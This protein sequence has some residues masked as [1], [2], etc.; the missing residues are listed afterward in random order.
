MDPLD[1]AN[2]TQPPVRCKLF[3]CLYLPSI[4]FLGS[5]ALRKSDR[6]V[7][8]CTATSFRA[9]EGKDESQSPQNRPL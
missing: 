6:C 7:R 4:R 2:T 3:P 8:F 9:P 1:V 5:K